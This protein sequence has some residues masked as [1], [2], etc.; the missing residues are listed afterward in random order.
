[1]LSWCVGFVFLIKFAFCSAKSYL[2][3]SL[4]A[5]TY[6]LFQFL[7]YFHEAFFDLIFAGLERGGADI[8]GRGVAV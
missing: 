4:S 1:M 8:V 2:T 3:L 6:Y 5:I 7:I